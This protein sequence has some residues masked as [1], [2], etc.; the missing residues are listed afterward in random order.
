MGCGKKLVSDHD[1]NILI[2]HQ[3]SA[4]Q[5]VNKIRGFWYFERRMDTHGNFFI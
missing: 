5:I 3:Y 4:V 2:N 1:T